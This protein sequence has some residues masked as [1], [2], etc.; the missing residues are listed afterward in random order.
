MLY[1][2]NL[3]PSHYYNIWY[4][5]NCNYIVVNSSQNNFTPKY[6]I[7]KQIWWGWDELFWRI[8]L[9]F[10]QFLSDF[11]HLLVTLWIFRVYFPWTLLRQISSVF[12]NITKFFMKMKICQLLV[13]TSIFCLL[14]VNIYFDISIEFVLIHCLLA[15]SFLNNT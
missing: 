11:I 5:N 6:I 10:E 1:R 15:F 9:W 2:C 4:D 3:I 7:T 8:K 13:W 14:D 12:S